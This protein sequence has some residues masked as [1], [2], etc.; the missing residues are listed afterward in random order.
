ME[1]PAATPVAFVLAILLGYKR[2]KKDPK[3]A[4]QRAQIAPSLLRRPEGRITASQMETLSGFAMQELDDEAVGWFSRRLPWGSYGMLCRGSLTAP[5][6]GIAL[7]RWCRHHRL[8]TED[9]ILKLNV[10]D[11]I[12]SLSI[13]ER[14]DFGQMRELCLIT[15]M[16]FVLGYAC[17]LIDSRIALDET[18]LPFDAPPN[19]GVYPLLFSPGPVRFTSDWTGFCFDARY[20]DLSPRRDE[21]SIS[22]MLKRALPLTVL[23]YC[24]DALLTERAREELKRSRHSA[25][26]LARELNLS[27]RTMYRQFKEEG[28]SLQALKD[29][30]GRDRASDLLRRTQKPIKQIA[31]AV[32]FTNEKSFVRAFRSWTGQTPTAYRSG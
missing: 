13:E 11:G 3:A 23:K 26:S 16:R 10:A 6:L 9:L 18:A 8:L 30:A 29:E 1:H 32:G 21:Q 17:W 14:R 25:F 27:V 4:L 7:N 12:A 5:T 19:S 20:L 15:T 28:T 24:R 2:Y 22:K 31:Q